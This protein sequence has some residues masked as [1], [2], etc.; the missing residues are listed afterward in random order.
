M[1]ATALNNILCTS[2]DVINIPADI[3]EDGNVN[4]AVSNVMPPVTPNNMA[5][6]TKIIPLDASGGSAGTTSGVADDSKPG[7][8]TSDNTASREDECNCKS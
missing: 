1:W 2:T 3:G 5:S 4:T 7:D 6:G 8:E